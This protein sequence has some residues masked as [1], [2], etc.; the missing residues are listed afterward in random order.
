MVMIMGAGLNNISNITPAGNDLLDPMACLDLAYLVLGMPGSF[1]FAQLQPVTPYQTT[2][3]SIC[4]L[5]V[6]LP[7]VGTRILIPS[8]ASMSY[9]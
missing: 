9:M 7:R 1:V 6:G 3:L 2:L 4:K 5:G 8:D